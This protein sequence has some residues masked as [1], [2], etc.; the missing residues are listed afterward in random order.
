VP[1][2]GGNAPTTYSVAAQADRYFP[3]SPQPSGVAG[4]GAVTA[5][6]V[7]LRPQ[8]F[9]RIGGIVY[10]GVPDANDLSRTR[11]VT[12]SRNPLAGALVSNMDDPTGADGRYT[13]RPLFIEN[14][15]SAQWDMSAS[16]PGYWP[17][18]PSD[19]APR[20]VTIF[21]GQISVADFFLCLSATARLRSRSSKRSRA[22]RCRG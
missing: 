6:D 14:G 13:T 5:V 7:Q 16:H 22:R 3:A 4:C 10:E 1:L 21:P 20:R 19:L 15:V 12:S 18:T 9:G 11:A 2:T 17:S 8:Q